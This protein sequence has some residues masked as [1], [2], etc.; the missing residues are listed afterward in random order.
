MT[1][2][3]KRT[4]GF[5][6]TLEWLEEHDEL[7]HKEK[8]EYASKMVELRKEEEEEEEEEGEGSIIK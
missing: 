1:K 7:E 4:P 5:Y 2:L 6:P 8:R 3:I